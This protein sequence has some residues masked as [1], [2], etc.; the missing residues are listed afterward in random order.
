MDNMTNRLLDAVKNE[1]AI[2]S[3][4]ALAKR[5]NVNQT[6]VSNYR[7]GRTQMD[8]VIACRVADLLNKPRGTVLA[9]LAVERAKTEEVKSALAENLRKLGGMAAAVL[10]GVG[11]AGTPGPA[12]ALF[13][14][15]QMGAQLTGNTHMRTKRRKGRSGFAGAAART[16]SAIARYTGARP[17]GIAF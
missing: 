15:N 10:V 17:A 8:E 7:A 6:T 14:N 12:Q 4:Y 16:L 9:A 2:K 13:N 11:L 1:H 5:L 3:D